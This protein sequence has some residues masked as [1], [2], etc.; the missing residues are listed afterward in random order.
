MLTI[1]RVG[2]TMVV[3]NE[4]G[5]TKTFKYTDGIE[6]SKMYTMAIAEYFGVAN[7]K[8]SYKMMNKLRKY[9]N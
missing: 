1:E 5:I 8:L 3:T 6:E 9:V 2:N 7:K 4:K